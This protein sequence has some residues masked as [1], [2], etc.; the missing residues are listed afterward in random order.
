MSPTR[1]APEPEP[2]RM[3]SI[4]TLLEDAV[5]AEMG[6][7]QLASARAIAGEHHTGSDPVAKAG[8]FARAVAG[9]RKGQVRE[10]YS[11]MAAHL[12]GPLF[13]ALPMLVR[14]NPGTMSVLMH[15]NQIAPATL[16]AILP[17]LTPPEFDVELLG[18]ESVLLRFRGSDETAGAVEGAVKGCAGHF[19]ER[20][21]TSWRESPGPVPGR[22]LLEVSISPGRDTPATGGAAEGTSGGAERRWGSRNNGLR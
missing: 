14:A 10:S 7:P 3:I 4:V 2:T 8:A 13:R 19:G 9:L 12:V 20:V 5:K 18:T 16:D 15:V 22:H 17:G 1:A 21:E 11:W 6:A